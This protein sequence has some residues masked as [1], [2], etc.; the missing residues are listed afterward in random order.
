MSRLL[1]RGDWVRVRSAAEIA[2]TL[3]DDGCL[4]GLPFMPE[5]VRLCG[6]RLQVSRRADK[7]CVE[8]YGLRRLQGA[9]HLDEV[10]CDGSAHD[11][12]QRNCLIF[13]K[14]AWLEPVA[15]PGADPAPAERADLPRLPTRLGRRY[16]CQSTELGGASAP[17]SPWDVAHLAKDVL[18][19]ELSVGGLAAM[20][21]RILTNR[22]RRAI[23]LPDLQALQGSGQAPARPGLG[24]QPGERVRVR[25]AQEISGTLGPSG[26]A[27]G[28]SFE[29]EMTGYVG[30]VYEV[31]FR[32][33]R[34]ILEETGKMVRLSDTVALK[35]LSCRGSCVKNCPRANTLYWRESWLERVE[36]RAKSA[37]AA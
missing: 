14:E 26:K 33:E 19:R 5:M 17:L 4:D 7:T 34:I 20:V 25:S 32:V 21:C 27:A 12:C 35:G 37:A 30:G 23:G 31:E 13:W 9:V 10:R 15:G 2:A 29:P 24:L 1:L 8:G 36:A 22:L 16:R 3:D 28:L 18:R 11:G 6:Q